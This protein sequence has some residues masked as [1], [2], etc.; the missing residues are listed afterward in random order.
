MCLGIPG[1]LVFG[2]FLV[3]WF[4]LNIEKLEALGAWIARLFARWSKASEKKFIELDIQSKVND[5]SKNVAREIGIRGQPGVK[6]EWVDTRSIDRDAFF[7]EGQ[8]VLRMST[9]RRQEENIV[10][11]TIA[12]IRKTVLFRARSYFDRVIDKGI[13]LTLASK[14]FVKDKESPALEYF[15]EDILRPAVQ[16]DSELLECLK[17]LSEMDRYGYFTRIFLRELATFADKFPSLPTPEDLAETRDFADFLFQIVM[18][19]EDAPLQFFGHRIKVG[20]ILVARKGRAAVGV[21]GPYLKAASINIERGTK[22][23]YVCSRGKL[24]VP[25]ARKVVEQ[26]S[27]DMRVYCKEKDEYDVEFSGGYSVPALW[28]YFRSVA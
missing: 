20:I 28:A 11:A 3:I 21:L 4:A 19:V 2:I 27:N 17:R 6:I 25:F 16:A 5:F 14:V 9:F 10:N 13:D 8:L 18:Q 24:N 12:Y 7:K 1:I 15:Q 26:L 22:T 23:I